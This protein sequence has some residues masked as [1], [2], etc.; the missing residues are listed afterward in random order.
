[1]IIYGIERKFKLTVG[2]Y[3]KIA[4]LLPSGNIEELRTALT[5]DDPFRIMEMIFHLAVIMN[6]QFEKQMSFIDRDY[7]KN[8][9]LTL[10]ELETL[11]IDEAI[12]TL[13]D[14]IIRSIVDSQKT[15]INVKKNRVETVNDGV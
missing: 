1:M 4:E 2:R 6:E 14:E 10:A 12:G 8:P 15:E 5:S 7:V 9:P 11:S 13:K 3:K